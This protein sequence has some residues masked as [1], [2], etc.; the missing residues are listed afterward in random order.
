M[1]EL[2]SIEGT[3]AALY[4]AVGFAPGGAP[5]WERLRGIFLDDARLIP[6]QLGDPPALHVVDFDTWRRES[7]EFLAGPGREI[8]ARGFREAELASRVERFG[9]IAHSFSSYASCF[10]D[11]PEPFARGINSIQL[12][13]RDGRWWVA[14]IMWDVERAGV[15]I[16]EEFGG[17][18]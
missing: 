14:T 4:D 18:E 10:R 15:A 8:A 16:P 6:P 1:S 7:E 5:D 13:H 2:A 3:I 9:A 11:S 12:V 17:G